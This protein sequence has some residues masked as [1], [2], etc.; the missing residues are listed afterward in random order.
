MVSYSDTRSDEATPLQVGLHAA[1]TRREAIAPVLLAGALPPR[2]D[3]DADVVI[4]SLD[5]AAET[6]QA[7]ISALAQ[8]GVSRHVIVVDQGSSPEALTR[9]GRLVSGRPD[10]ALISLGA[11]LGVPGGR[12][13]ATALGRGRVIVGLDND[14]AFPEPTTLARAVATLEADPDLG[15]V[16]FRILMAGTARDDLSS[17]GY[18][19]AL[20]SR[21]GDS[22]DA[23]TFVGAGHAIRRTAWNEAGGYDAGLFFCFEEMD[24]CRRALA[25]GWRVRYRGD[26]AVLH[27]VSAERRVRWDGARWFYSVRNRLLIERR[28]GSS[29][30]SLLPRSAAYVVKGVRHGTGM[31]TVRAILAARR[32]AIGLQPLS[33]PEAGLAYLAR[34]DRV[35]RGGL[36][37]RLRREVL[38]PLPSAG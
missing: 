28:W 35:H 24:F 16:G 5:R 30:T 21:S 10:A 26:I 14:A 19:A 37:A 15:A 11:N 17:W 34:N 6:E 18:P 13:C 22:F 20:L 32:M 31:A 8:T 4:L 29:W 38:A 9:L 25:R 23:T 7:I 3:Y 1:R 33:M 27:H 36:L 12:N 2:S